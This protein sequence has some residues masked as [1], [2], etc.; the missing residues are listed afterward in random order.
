MRA[1]RGFGVGDFRLTD[2]TI[3]IDEIVDHGGGGYQLA[4]QLQSFPR[5]LRGEEARAGDV[6]AR[7]VEAGDEAERDR[8]AAGAED[9]RDGGGRGFGGKRRFR[10]AG[11]TIT[12]MRRRTRSAAKPGRRSG[13]LFAHRYSMS[14]LPPSSSSGHAAAAPPSAVSN[15]RRP[16]VTVI[17]PSRARC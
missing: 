13:S 5:D 15:S 2:G 3:G 1:R 12:A 8:V 4:Q 7:P 11:L 10:N 14:T 16:M 6:A 9:D 17:R